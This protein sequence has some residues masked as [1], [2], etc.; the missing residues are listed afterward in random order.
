MPMLWRDFESPMPSKATSPRPFE[1]PRRSIRRL[2]I[3]GVLATL[4]LVG[5]LGGWVVTTHISGAVIAQGKLIV[6][7]SVKKVQH[8]IGG[9]VGELKIREGDHVRAGDVLLRL[10]QT[11]AR[12]NLQIV[13]QTLDELAARRARDEAERD[14]AR[15][16]DF[17]EI[18]LARIADPHVAQLVS[19]EK[20]LFKNRRES[21]EGEKRQLQEQVSQLGEQAN[22]LNAELAAKDQ[23]IRWNGEELKGVEDLWQKRLVQFVRLTGLQRDSARL[24]GERGQLVAALAEVR[25][26]KAETA[27]KIIQIDA[28]MR[29]EVA[30]EIGEIRAKTSELE[31]KRVSAEDQLARIELK[32]PQDGYVH[33]LSVHTVGGVIMAGE[34][35]M[36]IVPDDDTL[37]VEVHIQPSDIEQIHMG[38]A[39]VVRFNGLDQR[40]TPDLDG[41]VSLISADLDQDDKTGTSY[42]VLRISLPPAQIARLETTTLVP[43]MPVESFIQTKPRTV[44]SYLVQP[45]RDQIERAFRER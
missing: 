30:K 33:Q 28:D 7:S 12:A 38:Q 16:I 43:G 26:K 27:L 23:E 14:N 4:L 37:I 10:D 11:Q 24:G 18:L 36:T 32:A 19:E 1:D 42:Y 22:G 40:T 3:A 34:T 45:M 17:P 2:S 9:I 20:T 44:M 21:R 35:L 29:T 39:A 15:E 25:F 13:R 6:D 31:E 5:G 8:P 41:K